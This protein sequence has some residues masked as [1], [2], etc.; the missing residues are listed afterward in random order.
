M[1]AYW[2]SI[3]GMP[4]SSDFI[5][6]RDTKDRRPRFK[7]K[8]NV[9]ELDLAQ[10]FFSRTRK[11]GTTAQPGDP[12]GPVM[13]IWRGEISG[14]RV[15]YKKFVA[16]SVKGKWKYKDRLVSFPNLTLKHRDGFFQDGG[17]WLDFRQARIS[18]FHFRG[19]L[20]DF[21]FK[22][23]MDEVFG[24][25]FFVDGAATGEGYLSGRFIDGALDKKS[26]NGYFK[27]VVRDGSLIGYNLG[28]RLLQFMGFK[29]DQ[30]KGGLA[31]DRAKTK[32]VFK[33]GV[34]YF[35]D[36]ELRSPLLEAH[37]AGQVDL[38]NSSLQLWVSAYPLEVLS[39][40]TKPL[41][42]IG[43]LINQTQES[44]FGYYAKAEGPWGNYKI[45]VYRPLFEKVP[46]APKEEPFP[47]RPHDPSE[48]SDEGEESGNK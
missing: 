15:K 14:T 1:P 42:L 17:T 18:E 45:S 46:E 7:L 23:L 36:I 20:E 19:H 41:P 4:I 35:D 22:K 29:V 47:Q 21:E 24:L 34:I 37:C 2:L 40:L 43:A 31:F 32:L 38:V 27:V 26:L 44:L 30:S 13:S 16:D 25:D 3:S 9:N 28:L 33:D 5:Y 10:L 6:N 8:S 48:E 12:L 39:T 11:F